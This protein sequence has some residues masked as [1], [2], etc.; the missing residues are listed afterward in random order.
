VVVHKP[1]KSKN[2]IIMEIIEK[3]ETY[4]P[5]EDDYQKVGNSYD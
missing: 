4:S 1:T 5:L 2:Q 3:E